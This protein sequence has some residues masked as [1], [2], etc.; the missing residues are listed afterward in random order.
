M[1]MQNFS[2]QIVDYKTPM[3]QS[4][5]YT[6]GVMFESSIIEQ[7]IA[8]TQKK[9]FK[10]FIVLFMA[11]FLFMVTVFLICEIIYLAIFTRRIFSTINDLYDKIDMLSKQ[12][13]KLHKNKTLGPNKSKA[14]NESLKSQELDLDMIVNNLDATF[15]NI[16]MNTRNLIIQSEVET[17]KVDVLQDYQ[18]N[19]SC[20]EVTKLYRAANKLIKTLS[21][22]KTSILQGNDNTALLSYNEVA[23]LFEERSYNHLV[24]SIPQKADNKNQWRYYPAGQLIEMGEENLNLKEL[25]LSSNLAICYNNIACIHAKK[26][27]FIKQNLYFEEAIRIEELIVRAN[28]LDRNFTTAEEN[29]RLAVKHFNYG[30]SLYRQYMYLIKTQK[31]AHTKKQNEQGSIQKRA[32]DNLKKSRKYFNVQLQ[33]MRKENT[34]QKGDQL[35]LSTLPS[36]VGKR[37]FRDVGIFIRML[38][39]EMKI[40][41]KKTYPFIDVESSIQK[42]QFELFSY[43]Q[44]EEYEDG[45]KQDQGKKNKHKGLWLFKADTLLQKMLFLVGLYYEQRGREMIAERNEMSRLLCSQYYLLSISS[46]IVAHIELAQMKQSLKKLKNFFEYSSMSLQSKFKVL[47]LLQKFQVRNRAVQVI[48]ELC[49]GDP[50]VHETLLSFVKTTIFDKLRD[51][52]HFGLMTMRSGKQPYALLKLEEKFKNLKIKQKVLRELNLTFRS[53][54]DG[55]SCGKAK[56]WPLRGPK[57]MFYFDDS[58]VSKLNSLNQRL[59]LYFTTKM[60]R[61]NC[62][63]KIIRFK[64]NAKLFKVK[65]DGF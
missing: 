14:T 12:H 57:I 58:R 35:S 13:S 37:S 56:H 17:K 24:A 64:R 45:S 28:K 5:E 47:R 60:G 33:Q 4:K 42:L 1:M 49:N 6:M 7:K 2:V 50:T 65:P 10:T 55:S 48:M 21:L 59:A 40:Y 32:D 43:L 26:R 31:M 23:H 18:G 52:D 16:S 25:G 8:T 61:R 34:T 53:S 11:P 15:L 63:P 39:V 9:F 29:F 54:P 44:S 30:Y 41:S 19:E 3:K 22:A 27:N 20:M 62:R 46:N 51:K 36:I 38:Q